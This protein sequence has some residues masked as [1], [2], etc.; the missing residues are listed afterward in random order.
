M[1]STGLY[2]TGWLATGP[3]GVI[4]STMTQAYG[5]GRAAEADVCSGHVNVSQAR[6]GHT[7]VAKLL[8]D[9]SMY[10][11][12]GWFCLSSALDFICQYNPTRPLFLVNPQCY[13]RVSIHNIKSD[14]SL[15]VSEDGA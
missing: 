6:P 14:L 8:N 13:T 12:S 7:A 2:V 4:L 10:I 1:L 5:A 3:V 15:K 11:H 9:R